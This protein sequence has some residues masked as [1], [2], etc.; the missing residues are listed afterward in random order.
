MPPR[1]HPPCD[2]PVLVKH[3]S[4]TQT[5]NKFKQLAVKKVSRKCEVVT[6]RAILMCSSTITVGLLVWHISQHVSLLEVLSAI[7][8]ESIKNAG[9]ASQEIVA[10]LAYS[11]AI[12]CCMPSSV[13]G[14][15]VGLLEGFVQGLCTV[16]IGELLAS[17]CTFILARK[18]FRKKFEEIF[19]SKME[20]Q[21]WLQAFDKLALHRGIQMSVALRITPI[22]TCMKNYGLALGTQ[23]SFYDFFIGAIIGNIPYNFFFVYSGSRF[24][25]VTELSFHHGRDWRGRLQA[26]IVE[27]CFV[28]L[29]MGGM[30]R[31][32]KRVM[33]ETETEGIEFAEMK[34][35]QT[36]GRI[37]ISL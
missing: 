24:Q 31:W 32:A 20:Q 21:T 9:G 25:D 12:V 14:M 37:A 27:M 22:P 15:Y 34:P 26:A 30:I 18:I 3:N 16:G 17:C 33:K 4:E 10:I 1:C 13:L 6:W 23:I 35:V 28:L 2:H 7:H 19:R 29:I 8:R 11:A 5:H 36:T